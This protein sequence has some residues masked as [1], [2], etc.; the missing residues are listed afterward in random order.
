ME[1]TIRQK[2]VRSRSIRLH[3]HQYTGS[4]TLTYPKGLS[5]SKRNEHLKRWSGWMEKCL[6]EQPPPVFTEGGRVVLFGS[7][8]RI[9]FV[10]PTAKKRRA[11]LKEGEL[12]LY[13]SYPTEERQ[14]KEKIEALLDREILERAEKWIEFY[15]DSLELGEI[16]VFVRAMRSRW[17][18]CFPGKKKV[19]LSRYLIYKDEVFIRDVI[20]HELVHF[21]H[22]NHQKGFKEL[23]KRCRMI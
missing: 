2:S 4:F 14:R 13:G 1:F 18:S 11:E 20:L 15:R 22:P 19:H 9:R 8:R 10:E 5:A 7:A 12:L 3:Y 21:E 17:G 16:S 23:L 6:R